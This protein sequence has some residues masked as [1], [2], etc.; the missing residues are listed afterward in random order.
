MTDRNRELQSALVD[1][2]ATRVVGI[3][4]PPTDAGFFFG[5]IEGRD[6]DYAMVCVDHVLAMAEHL[7]DSEF[8][9]FAQGLAEF[10]EF[11]LDH[12]DETGYPAELL[13]SAKDWVESVSPAAGA[14]MRSVFDL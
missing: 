4:T 7:T 5:N 10:C 6:G 1:R 13:N 3:A 14:A 12:P 9:V 8:S 2:L 11:V